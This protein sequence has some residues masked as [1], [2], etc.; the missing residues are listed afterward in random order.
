[1]MAALIGKSAFFNDPSSGFDE[2]FIA[3][4]R[5]LEMSKAIRA[6]N[7]GLSRSKKACKMAPTQFGLSKTGLS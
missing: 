7:R 1:M 2:Y 5:G 6:K 4:I 3:D